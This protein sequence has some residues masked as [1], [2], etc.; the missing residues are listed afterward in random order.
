M[1]LPGLISVAFYRRRP[2]WGRI[3]AGLVPTV[4]LS[5]ALGYV[6]PGGALGQVGSVSLAIVGA[7][8]IYFGILGYLFTRYPS[9]VP[10]PPT[11]TDRTPP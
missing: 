3:S 10:Q 6:L 4:A 9:K 5:A 8:A 11:S 7:V 1:M 2:S